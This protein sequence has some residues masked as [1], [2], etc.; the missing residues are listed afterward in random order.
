MALAGVKRNTIIFGDWRY[1]IRACRRYVYTLIKSSP[2]EPSSIPY[3]TARSHR[4]Q[5]ER[6][7]CHLYQYISSVIML[8][9]SCGYPIHTGWRIHETKDPDMSRQNPNQHLYECYRELLCNQ[10]KKL[11][12]RHSNLVVQW[13]NH[14]LTDRET[15]DQLE[16]D[17]NAWARADLE[18]LPRLAILA[19][20]I[21]RMAA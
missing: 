13:V 1:H 4:M 18:K 8:C 5:Q 7:A 12:I 21:V 3:K 15:I 14:L 11:Q 9:A 19:R 20:F 2:Q 10:I 17:G 6:R 16:K